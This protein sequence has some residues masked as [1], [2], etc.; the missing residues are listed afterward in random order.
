MGDHRKRPP[1]PAWETLA[2]LRPITRLGCYQLAREVKGAQNRPAAAERIALKRENRNGL[3]SNYSTKRA[4][5]LE[6]NGVINACDIPV[7]IY[8]MA[9]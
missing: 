2:S 6:A 9:I 8:G 3:G 7:W 1:N 5:I 4:V